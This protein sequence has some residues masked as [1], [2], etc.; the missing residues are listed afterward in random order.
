VPTKP[1]AWRFAV[2]NFDAEGVDEDES[3][4]AVAALDR[5]F[6]REPAAKG[7]AHDVDLSVGQV[8]QDV[9]IEVHQVVHRVKIVGACRMAKA[10]M[11]RGNNLRLTA[12]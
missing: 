5:D 3:V 10:G 11:G 8:V 7:Q 12:Q 4:D 9:E 2:A 1:F 6:R